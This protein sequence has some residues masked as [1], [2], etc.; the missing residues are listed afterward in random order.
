MP[1]AEQRGGIAGVGEQFGDGVFPRRQPSLPLPGKRDHVGPRANRM[2]PRM[3]SRA[4]RRALDLYVVVVEANA[5]AG[6]LV[7]ARRG[8]RSA[9]HPEIAPADVVHQNEH[10]VGLPLLSQRRPGDKYHYADQG[11]TEGSQT[12]AQ[13]HGVSSGW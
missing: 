12:V 4:R 8:Y 11:A 13:F 1:L 9:V 3:D 5:L 2:P 7:D 6:Q 10:H